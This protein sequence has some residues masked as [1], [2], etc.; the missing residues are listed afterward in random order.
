MSNVMAWDELTLLREEAVS[1]FNRRKKLT[2]KD[3]ERF[4]VA[5]PPSK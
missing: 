4:C 1:T 5:S 2:Q 3:V